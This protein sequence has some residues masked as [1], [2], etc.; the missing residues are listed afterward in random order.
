MS[1]RGLHPPIAILGTGLCSALGRGAAATM[2]GL[3][4]GSASPAPPRGIVD[5]FE[6]RR[7][8]FEVPDDVFLDPP[9]PL[10]GGRGRRGLRLALLAAH[11]ALAQAGPLAAAPERTA[12]IV[13]TTVGGMNA[14]EDWIEEFARGG[15]SPGAAPV[16][17]SAMRHL[18]LGEIPRQLARRLRF[19][20]PCM[21]V[22]TA[23]T[24][25]S[26][27]IAVGADLLASGAV[28]AV[29]AGGVD[30]LS[31]ITHHGFASLGLLDGK[32]CA[33][34]TAERVGLNL[35]EGAAFLLLVRDP[36]GR[37]PSAWLR[38]W[39]STSDAHHATA[40]SPDGAGTASALRYALA[41]ARWSP[42][43]VDWIH[44]HG[45]ATPTNDA[46]ESAAI[47]SVFGARPV[48]VSSTKHHCGHTLGAAGALAAVMG[49]LAMEEGFLPGNTG[50]GTQ[51]PT[52]AVHLVPPAGL[53][54]PASRIVINALGFG[55]VN[56]ALALS[57]EGP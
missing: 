49:V 10:P 22:T 46:A 11:D 18:P 43:D 27:A 50:E 44:A 4:H 1:A 47:A 38:G 26:Q 39:S 21:A 36:E 45:T 33:P 37:T 56:V 8:V 14:A 41:A 48:P 51:D 16:R 55:G 13:G 54:Q 23:C 7:P 31:R 5:A 52:C 6:G 15:P 12:V 32:R 19:R 40:P 29:L 17:R 9:I 53:V 24:S 20:G 30:V 57:G 34:F 2:H 42:D 25:G 3:R 28:D 35:G